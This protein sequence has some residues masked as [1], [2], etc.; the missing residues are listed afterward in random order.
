M[1]PVFTHAD[2]LFSL[3]NRLVRRPREGELPR[4]VPDRDGIPVLGLVGDR[5]DRLVEQIR[6]ALGEAQPRRVP[7]EI[8]DVDERWDEVNRERGDLAA[9]WQRSEVCRRVLVQLAQE[10]SSERGGHDRRVRFRRFG[11]VNWLLE[12][13]CTDEEPD[14]RHDQDMLSRLR[15]REFQRRPVLGFLRAPGTEVALQGK[16][17]WWAYVFGLYVLPLMWFRAWRVLGG[18][19]RWLLRQPY[20]AP[21]DPGTFAGFA[22]RLTQPRWGRED[23]DQVVKLMIN[24]FLE[25]LRVA[26]RR[27]PW[28][29]RAARRTA[30]CVAFLKG[31]SDDNRGRELVRSFVE[32]RRETG[33]FDP[34]LIVTSC[35]EGEH[36]H[37]RMRVRSLAEELSPYEAWCERLRGA[38]RSRD[39]DFW[40]LPVRVPAPLPDG[41]PDLAAQSEC[42]SAARRFTVG[43]PPLWAGRAATAGVVAL[44]LAL[45]AATV[46]A[47]VERDDRWRFAHCGQARSKADAATVTW[48]KGTRECVG[49]ASHGFA[50]GSHDKRLTE[51]LQ[52]IADQN[53]RAERLHRDFDKRPLVTLVHV[54]AMLSSPDGQSLKALSYAREQLQGVASAQRRQLDG[55]GETEPVLRILSANAGSGMRYGVRVAGMVRK[56]ME[57]DPTIV[58]VT[59]LDESREDTVRTIGALTRAGLPMV[60]TTP[61]ADTLDDHSPLYH[62]VSPQNAREAEV[63]AA[64]ADELAEKGEKVKKREVLVLYSA[65]RSDAYSRTL[66][67]DVESAFKEKGFTVTPWEFV[68]E[69]APVGSFSGTPGA[70]SAGPDVCRDKK[71]MVFFAGRSEDFEAILGAVDQTCGTSEPFILGGDDVARLGADMKRRAYFRRLEYDF[72]DFTRNTASCDGAGNLYS[73]MKVLFQEEC[74]S[75]VT[76]YLDGHAALAF[77]AVGV[78]LKAISYLQESARGMP[79]TPHAV[80]QALGTVHGERALDGE[81]GT[82][83]FGGETGGH[84]PIDKLISVQRV[85]NGGLPTQK[86]LC[87]RVGDG[88]QAG[89]CP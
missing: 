43:R 48:E 55:Q 63:A 46:A 29:R 35:A 50:F 7:H 75:L 82:I 73:T 83:D 59:G 22:L 23:P 5:Q 77:D 37:E 62:Q 21:G 9:D 24:A 13:T 52:V 10:Y 32:V 69:A 47:T 54:S 12:M 30:Y 11:L 74:P 65:D 87:G 42:T 41:H 8:I 84:T 70:H 53:E 15:D 16:V 56:L 49:V 66:W 67:K 72:L 68:S 19:Y 2:R 57:D 89:W 61:S 18:E 31:V 86:G 34:L 17:P 58:G 76:T 81:S 80:W 28:R 79:L 26:Y 64:Y 20:M 33:A 45:V 4:E 6:R 60:A 27:R 3:L 44:V 25:D 71:R 78:Y 1:E 88:I 51:T 85:V 38:G 39:A 36:D 40:Y 14:S